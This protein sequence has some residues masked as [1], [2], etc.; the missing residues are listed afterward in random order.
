V[1]PLNILYLMLIIVSS[2]KILTSSENMAEL[3]RKANIKVSTLRS[4]V[5]DGT[6]LLYLSLCGE[7]F[8][9]CHFLTSHN[10]IIASPYILALLAITGQKAMVC[11]KTI[12]NDISSL[13]TYFRQVPGKSC[14]FICVF[15]ND[16]HLYLYQMMIMGM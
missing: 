16:N 15:Y 8:S 9:C 12:T 14:L 11:R 5:A 4:M 13:G 6:K 10:V 3:A 7:E 2:L 1:S